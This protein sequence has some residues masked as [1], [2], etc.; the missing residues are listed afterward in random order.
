MK[1]GERVLVRGAL[2]V[3]RRAARRVAVDELTYVVVVGV[4]PGEHVG[5][6]SGVAA[7]SVAV[8]HAQHVVREQAGRRSH[9][10]VARG[11]TEEMPVQKAPLALHE[12]VVVRRRHRDDVGQEALFH[13]RN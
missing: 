1:S 9:S 7:R 3:I 4:V 13:D 5:D 12:V 6:M 11:E 8:N 2:G 10:R